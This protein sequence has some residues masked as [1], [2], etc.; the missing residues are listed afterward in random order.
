MDVSDS[1]ACWPVIIRAWP[2]QWATSGE[3]QVSPWQTESSLPGDC[4]VACAVSRGHAMQSYVSTRPR[5]AANPPNPVLYSVSLS[6]QELANDK[7]CHCKRFLPQ[8]SSRRHTWEQPD[9]YSQTNTTHRSP[10]GNQQR[11][12][13]PSRRRKCIVCVIL[14][15]QDF[16]VLPRPRTKNS[17]IFGSFHL[18]A[19]NSWSP[20]LKE[21]SH[22][23]CAAVL[24]RTH[25]WG[26]GRS[27][28]Q[29]VALYFTHYPH[30]PTP[31][32]TRLRT[33]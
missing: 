25:A 23:Q 32:L 6:E 13:C 1:A 33:S 14:R 11:C 31:Q 29:P 28:A 16:T 9:S 3:F 2:S 20:S 18:S 12:M 4:C 24:L 30:P 26:S 15:V 19:Q 27:A 21:G 22:V 7:D 5:K 8:I 17:S 10:S